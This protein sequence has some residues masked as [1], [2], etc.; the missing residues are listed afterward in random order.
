MVLVSLLMVMLLM[1][2]NAKRAMA[3]VDMVPRF[4]GWMLT[5]KRTMTRSETLGLH[6]GMD[7]GCYTGRFEAS[8][9]ERAVKRVRDHHG[10]KRCLFVAAPDVVGD[11]KETLT[12]AAKWIDRIRSWGMPVALVAQDGM[13]RFAL[14]WLDVDALF[15]GGSMDWKLSP[16]AGALMRQAR[17]KGKWVHVGRIGSW[18]GHDRMPARAD[19]IDGTSFLYNAGRRLRRWDR[20]LWARFRE[21]RYPFGERA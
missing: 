6:Y 19:S 2:G 5:A 12:L 10:A 20:H 17:Q 18:T 15:V 13:E 21:R 7:N 4:Y 14:P 8:R 11:A 16:A 3:A 9:F 1:P